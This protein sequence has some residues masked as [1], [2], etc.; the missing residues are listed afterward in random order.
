MVLTVDYLRNI[1]THTLLAIDT[2]H[3]GDARFFNL[4]NAM[5]AISATNASLG[6]PGGLGSGLDQLCDWQG[7]NHQQLCL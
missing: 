6:C 4:A 7:R 2:N 1:E 5:A 3:V